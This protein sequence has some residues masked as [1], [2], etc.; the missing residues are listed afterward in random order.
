MRWRV[1]SLNSETE[2][3]S[4]LEWNCSRLVIRV[5]RLAMPIAPPRLRVMKVADMLRAAGARGQIVI[6]DVDAMAHFLIDALRGHVHMEVLLNPTR[7]PTAKEI[8][9]HV[10]FVVEN[11]LRACRPSAHA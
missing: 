8:E 2:S 7:R 3:I 10:D 11:F 4:V 5:C 9:R 1:A 6:S